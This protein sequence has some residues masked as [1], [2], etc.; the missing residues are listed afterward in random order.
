MVS[1]LAAKKKSKGRGIANGSRENK[2]AVLAKDCEGM[3]ALHQ[4]V[5]EI[6]GA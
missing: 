2:P 5:R 1:S 3:G 6:S 4:T